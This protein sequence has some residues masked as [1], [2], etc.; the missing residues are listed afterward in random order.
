M[1][2]TAIA[3]GLAAAFGA[4][5]QQEEI[6]ALSRPESEIS[7]GAGFVT[8]DNLRFGQYTGMRKD[9]FYGLIDFDVSRRDDAAGQWLEFSGRN[10]GLESR[11]LRFE[12]QRQGNWGYFIDFSQTPRYSP[13]IANTAV[14]GIG[15]NSLT[16]PYPAATSPK[17]NVQLSTK[18][19]A[20]TLGAAKLWGGGWDTQVRYRNEE[21]TGARIFGRGTTGGAG[22]GGQEFTPEPIDYLTQQLEVTVGLTRERLQLSGGY[23]GSWFQNE[24]SALNISNQP[25]GPTALG[26]GAGAFTPIGLPP[27]NQAHQLHL[28]G[29]FSFTPTTRATFKIAHARLT[30]DEAFIVPASAFA[31]RTSL[32]GRVDTTQLQLGLATRP[33]AKLSLRADLRYEDRDDKTPTALYQT[34]NATTPLT[35]ANS[36]TATTNGLNEP[37]SIRTGAG[38]LEASYGLPAGF[39]VTGGLDY[40]EKKRNTSDVRSVSHRF[41]TEETAWRAELRRSL[42]DTVNGALGFVHSKREGSPWLT[43]TTL[44]GAAGSNLV[45]P[46]HLAD[47][48]RDKLRAVLDWSP[49]DPLSLQFVAEHARDEYSGR[50]LG[51]RKGTASL[52]SADATYSFSERWQ[53]TAWASR[54]DTRA[55]QVTCES[56][57]GVGVCPNTAADPL[58]EAELGVFT[59]AFGL[60]LRATPTGVL[61][62]GADVTYARDRN[63]FRQS[64]LPV[65]NPVGTPLPDVNYKRTILGLSAK[66]ALARNSGLRLRY[67]YDRFTT[68]DYNWSAWVYTDGTTLRQDAKQEVHFVGLSYYFQFR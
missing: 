27:G 35:P 51:P 20:W 36:P 56:A 44:N 49:L 26:V 23:Y 19:E 45:H 46:L 14:G 52:Y 21:K 53:A 33:M 16:I 57:S 15:S 32:G 66:Y 62:V 2:E 50:T 54:N 22:V 37:R 6:T 41:E 58:W 39:R 9:G 42:S 8:N 25:G 64:P 60:G 38:K 67:A 55:E 61:E 65:P 48:D 31:A 10:V 43:T 18:R 17:S 30:Q 5:A 12:Q 63:E 3:L 40:E 34:F 29:G 28:A 4:H 13:Y 59:T 24:N 1:K 68:D 11:E 47:R 7:L